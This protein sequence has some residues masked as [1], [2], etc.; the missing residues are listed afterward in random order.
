MPVSSEVSVSGPF[1]PNG[2]TTAFPFTFKAT[3]A[4]EVVAVDQDGATIS[5]ALYSVTL[6]ADEGGSLNFSVAPV[7]ADYDAIYVVSNPALTQPSDFDNAGPSFNPAALTR[8][9]DRAAAR[10]LKQQR[11]I[12]RALKVA[13]GETALEVGDIAEGEVLARVGSAFVGVANGA[14]EFASEAAAAIAEVGGLVATAG[15]HATT[16]TTQAGVATTQAGISTTQAGLS[17]AARAGSETARGEAEDFRD[18]AEEQADL[19]IAAATSAPLRIQA[20]PATPTVPPAGVTDGQ[21]YWAVNADATVLTLYLN[22]TGTGAAVLVGGNNVAITLQEAI[23]AAL[24]AVDDAQAALAGFTGTYSADGLGG[25][26]VAQ[27]IADAPNALDLRQFGRFDVANNAFVTP[28]IT[29]TSVE[30]RWLKTLVGWGH[31]GIEGSGVTFSLETDPY[32]AQRLFLGQKNSLIGRLTARLGED[33][34]VYNRG[35]ATQP[36]EAIAARMGAVPIRLTVTGN[37][38]PASGTA[39]LTAITPKPIDP[40]RTGVTIFGTIGGVNVRLTRAT[41]SA[42]TMIA[43]APGAADAL[44]VPANSLFIP[45][46]GGLENAI[47]IVQLDRNGN[48]LAKMKYLSGRMAARVVGGRFLFMGTWNMQSQNETTG[49]A[50][51]NATIAINDAYRLMFPANFFD[52]RA[53]LRGDFPYDGTI[54]P[55]AWDVSGLSPT[56]NDTADIAAG[57]M[58][59]AFLAVGEAPSYSHLGDAGYDVCAKYFVEYLFPKMGWL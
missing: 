1:T 21:Q 34:E 29:R 55:S 52:M 8:A 3:A 13:F 18:E 54:E 22:T 2:V 26:E 49:T 6:D 15:G 10:D 12:D 50:G 4:N 51:Y 28:A 19:A 31:S 36:A 16:A 38:V 47:N 14:G 37:S 25:S 7:L 53:F 24:V 43:Q 35:I 11:E 9:L 45:T 46:T 57:Y 56:S 59:R 23:N 20:N 27:V 41:G 44:A 42:T 17:A 32:I 40:G 48:D 5:T 30:Q 58:P 33:W 39:N